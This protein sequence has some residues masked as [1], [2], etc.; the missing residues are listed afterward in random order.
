MSREK[1]KIIKFGSITE[2]DGVLVFKHFNIDCE[3][4]F[5]SA[6]IAMLTLV[7]DRIVKEIDEICSRRVK[8]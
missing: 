4:R 3:N 8:I 5:E 6:D 7:K 1:G 2:E